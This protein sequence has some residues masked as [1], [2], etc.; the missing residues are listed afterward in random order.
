MLLAL[1]DL[2]YPLTGIPGAAYRGF[3]R[4]GLVVAV[5]D[6]LRLEAEPDGRPRLLLTLLRGGGGAASTGGRLELGLSI[7]SDVEGIGRVLAAQ[8]TPVSLVVADLEDG[9]LTIEAL[10]GSLVP[11]PLAVPQILPPDLLTR[12]RIVVELSAEAAGLASR[13]IEDATLPVN[14]TMHLAFRAVAP[15]LPLATTYNPRAIA[16]GL[17]A[18]LGDGS[19]VTIADLDSAIDALLTGP[20]TVVE[21]DLQAIDPQLR[22]RTVALRLRERF[23]TRIASAPGTRQLFSVQ[24]IPSGRERLDF[25]EPAM[26]VVEQTISIDP[27]ATARSMRHGAIDDVVKRLEMP[28]LPIGRQ[29]LALSANLPEPIAGLQALVA[30]FHAPELPPFRPLAV[31]VSVSLEAPERRATAELR[32]APG[33]RLTGEVRLR[34]VVAKNGQAVEIAGPWRALQRADVLLGPGD[35]GAPLVVLR[36]SPALTALAVVEAIVDGTVV[37]RL[38]T[39]TRMTAIPLTEQG[40]RLLARPLAEGRDIEIELAGKKRL[41]LDVA[42]LPG[43]GAHRAR[44]VATD[45]KP[46]IVEWRADGD[47]GQEPLSV[48]MGADRPV[49]EIGWIAASPFRPGMVWRAVRDGTPGPWSAPVLPQDELLIEIDG[50][51]P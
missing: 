39:A 35:F 26:V 8:G 18:R 11:T 27:L 51:S 36:V 15:R 46:F 4:E 17:A 9:V 30:D 34:A 21:G 20:E 48:R 37:A 6:R 25:A 31:S 28:P 19:V 1:P 45:A 10:L 14:A 32:L 47:T 42:T 5:P 38:D 3:G 23:A 40:L 41:D 43:F 12:A 33:E 7:E 2:S 29:R 22:A 44:L 24:S 50:R 49:A 13:L 16:E